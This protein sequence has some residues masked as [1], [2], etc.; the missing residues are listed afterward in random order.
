MGK[1]VIAYLKFIPRSATVYVMRVV[2]LVVRVPAGDSENYITKVRQIA[3]NLAEYDFRV[4]LF[5]EN[6]EKPELFVEGDVI[7][8]RKVSVTDVVARIL[9]YSSVEVSDP[10]MLD[11]LAGAGVSDSAELLAYSPS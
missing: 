3:N 4:L 5:V 9:R 10:E 6:G 7:D 8:L 2:T 11:K 1:R